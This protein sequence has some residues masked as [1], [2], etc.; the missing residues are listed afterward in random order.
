MSK[1][2][3]LFNY[4]LASYSTTAAALFAMAGVAEAT[5][6]HNNGYTGAINLTGSDTATISLD[7]ST[8]FEFT[9]NT[10]PVTS[11]FSMI[12]NIPLLD[13]GFVGNTAATTDQPAPMVVGANIG[14]TLAANYTWQLPGLAYGFFTYSNT[15]QDFANVGAQYLGVRFDSGGTTVFGWIELNPQTIP[16]RQLEILGWAY[17]DSGASILAGDT[18]QA[19]APAPEP[20]GLALLALGFPG[21]AL[22]RRRR[23]GNGAEADSS[24]S[25][26]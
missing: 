21:L 2:N 3:E 23:K 26:A 13:I 17:E 4:R 5:I 8:D 7:G 15:P 14:P 20:S 19:P 24:A 6:V 22:M 16:S 25:T 10:G 11:A 12:L 18:G 1:N 9:L